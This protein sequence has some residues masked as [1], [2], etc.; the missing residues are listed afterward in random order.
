M[1]LIFHITDRSQWQAAQTIGEYRHPSLEL[2]GFIHCST[3]QQVAWVANSFFQGQSDL[4]LLEIDTDRL[5]PELRYDKVAG[6]GTFPHLY[7]AINLDAIN[8]AIKFE[9]DAA[10]EFRWPADSEA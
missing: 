4:L 10:G 7:G 9:P 1:A 6:V 2:E 8:R 3:E 5:K